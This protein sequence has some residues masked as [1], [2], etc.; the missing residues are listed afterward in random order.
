MELRHV[1]T[2]AADFG[3]LNF[4]TWPTR[5]VSDGAAETTSAVQRFAGLRRLLEFGRR[6]RDLGLPGNDLSAVFEANSLGSADKLTREV[7]PRM[8]RLTDRSE[9]TVRATAESL[10]AAPA[11]AAD[12]AV[13]RLCD[14][15][16]L[17]D[18]FGVAV[19]TLASC[20]D[21]LKPCLL[22]TSVAQ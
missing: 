5:E 10:W 19:A 7:Y 6:K 14:A 2:H 20:Q 18:R 4:S 21:L 1:S 12:P 15:L 9:A 16:R 8:A 22:S 3:Q 13:R 11:F 17:V